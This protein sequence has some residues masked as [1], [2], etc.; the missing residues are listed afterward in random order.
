MVVV[1]LRDRLRACGEVTA[2]H[3]PSARLRAHLS[4]RC[5]ASDNGRCRC[6]RRCRLSQPE[7]P[8]AACVAVIQSTSTASSASTYAA[9]LA[10]VRLTVET[11]PVR[12][13]HRSGQSLPCRAVS[14]SRR[15][16]E[17]AY[18][19]APG[20]VREWCAGGWSRGVCGALLNITAGRL[21]D[22][23]RLWPRSKGASPTPLPSRV[24]AQHD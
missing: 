16:R 4:V 17:A 3:C 12:G 24:H 13:T 23:V 18:S 5:C 10:N 21:S 22:A 8:R 20:S 9:I 7:C 6:S 2:D 19:A 1:A 15:V 11:D 14:A